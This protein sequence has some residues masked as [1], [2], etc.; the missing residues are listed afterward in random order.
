[1]STASPPF[2]A[3]SPTLDLTLK[4]TRS[5]KETS[6]VVSL[7]QNRNT[8]SNKFKRCKTTSP[9]TKYSQTSVPVSTTSVKV[10]RGF[11]NKSKADI[12]KKLWLPTKIDWRASVS[13]SGSSSV[14]G[15]ASSFSTLTYSHPTSKSLKTS[16]R[17]STFSLVGST[18]KESINVLSLQS[19]K[20]NK[21]ARAHL[22]KE[23]QKMAIQHQSRVSALDTTMRRCQKVPIY[24]TSLQHA[25]LLRW[26]RDARR[27]YNLAMTHVLQHRWH[28]L[29]KF[30]QFGNGVTE[31]VY[32]SQGITTMVYVVLLMISSV[33]LKYL[34]VAHV[35]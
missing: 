18:E 34:N 12:S 27:T 26:F 22:P 32:D 14:L 10:S 30:L 6:T 7:L 35:E 33:V 20:H 23:E 21:D 31:H 16:W 19:K 15:H 4:R 5:P 28:R 2:T 1:M 17:S 11:W 24:P 8:L 29:H 13:N 9:T 25:C 3:E